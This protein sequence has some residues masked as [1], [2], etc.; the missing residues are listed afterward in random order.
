MAYENWFYGPG[1]LNNFMCS[2][3]TCLRTLNGLKP[4]RLHNTF[5]H[6]MS[7]WFFFAVLISRNRWKT[8]IR[9]AYGPSI[10]A[11]ERLTRNMN[12]ATARTVETGVN[13]VF[14]AIEMHF[15]RENCIRRQIT[16]IGMH[17]TFY[18]IHLL[19]M[20]ARSVEWQSTGAF[21]V[22]DAEVALCRLRN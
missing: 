11:V 2:T 22:D 12:A 13:Y 18:V 1:K 3:W 6:S 10:K 16:H 19:T 17:K 21:F 5:S 9:K 20:P 8:S 15:E 7:F 14:N 4:C